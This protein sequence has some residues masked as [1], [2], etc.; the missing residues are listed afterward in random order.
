[1]PEQTPNTTA[2]P[3]PVVL[4]PHLCQV[5]TI[6]H[7]V[8]SGCKYGRLLKQ[9]ILKPDTECRFVVAP[10]IIAKTLPH[11]V[12][13]SDGRKLGRFAGR[14]RRCIRTLR[15]SSEG[16]GLNARRRQFHS[17]VGL[18]AVRRRVRSRGGLHGCKSGQPLECKWLL[19]FKWLQFAPGTRFWAMPMMRNDAHR[20]RQYERR[21]PP[22]D[23][24]Q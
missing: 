13:L 5:V 22:S 12:V 17:C 19:E 2:G 10:A 24:R 20:A 1:M 16:R 3:R 15:L 21:Q 11:R 4:L 18:S 8:A 6:H 9:L 7:A 23:I 14:G